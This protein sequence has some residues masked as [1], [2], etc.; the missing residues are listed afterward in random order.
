L[1]ILNTYNRF[2]SSRIPLNEFIHW[3]QYGPAGPASHALLET[4]D[5]EIVG[6][7]SLIPFRVHCNGDRVIPA[8]SEYSFLREEFRTEKV[9]GFEKSLRPTWLVLV[10]QHFRCCKSEGWG[11]FLISTNPLLYRLGPSIGCRRQDFHLRECLLVLRPWNSAKETPNLS[12]GRRVLLYFAGLVQTTLWWL[13]LSLFPGSSDLKSRPLAE[14]AWPNDAHGLSFFQDEKSLKWRYLEGQYECLRPTNDDR[15]YVIVK[16]G[17]E[18]R[19][20]RVCQWRLNSGPP[21]FS[22]IASL[23]RMAREQK[24]L[25]LRWAVYGDLGTTSK[26]SS[27]MRWLGFICERRV[28]NLLIHSDSPEPAADLAWNLNDSMFSFDP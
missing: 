17:A 19:Y 8:K 2:T 20:V 26:Y 7:H 4:D 23:V 15:D 10:S 16:N 27:R 22:L 13:I 12:R 6:H 14:C 9:R 25:G 28:R 24:A 21:T 11:P 18:D 5:G 3:L 1:T